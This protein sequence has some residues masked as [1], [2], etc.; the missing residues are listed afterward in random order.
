VRKHGEF[1]RLAEQ[2]EILRDFFAS[3]RTEGSKKANE[4]GPREHA[5]EFSRSLGQ[6]P[7]EGERKLAVR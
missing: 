6:K 5:Q 1:L 4:I 3:E 2:S 7:P